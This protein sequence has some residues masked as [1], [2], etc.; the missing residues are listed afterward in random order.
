RYGDGLF[1]TIFVSD[2]N[3]LFI[4]LH[5]N[6]LVAGM[7]MLEIDIPVE[8]NTDYFKNTIHELAT[9]N[10]FQNARCRITVWREGEGFYLPQTNSASL[11]IELFSSVANEYILNEK[12]VVLGVF[13]KIPKPIHPL[14]V[15]KTAN[16]L[17]YIMAAKFAREKK[18]DDVVILNNERRIADAVS[19]N[20][21][22]LKNNQ[23]HTPALNE[24]GIDG[25]MKKVIIELC[26]LEN[27]VVNETQLT[28]KDL[29]SA[30]EIFLTNVISGIRWVGE[31]QN[32]KYGNKFST[33][34][35]YIVNEAIRNN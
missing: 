20:I 29:I 12:G 7:Q 28:I 1:E 9:R 6:R 31:F 27:I 3:P 26:R 34:L 10:N 22:F 18:F 4:D 15:F 21:L 32:R 16:S 5:F 2:Q 17:V 30:D 35:I 24:G 23:L 19:S 8:W 13:E 33:D 14:S 11:L 25:V